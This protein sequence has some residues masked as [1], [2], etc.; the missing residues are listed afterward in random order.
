MASEATG[1]A[2]LDQF[3]ADLRK[4][5]EQAGQPSLRAMSRTAHYSHTALSG[6][7][8]S[9]RL[10]SL[11]LTLAFVGACGGDQSQWQARWHQVSGRIGAGDGEEPAAQTAD[12]R[13]RRRWRWRWRWPMTVAAVGLAVGSITGVAV[14]MMSNAAHPAQSGSN[15]PASGRSQGSRC[16]ARPD[17]GDRPLVPCDD[18]RFVADVTIPDGTTVRAGQEF[19]KTWE[20][21]NTGLVPWQ[22]R[23]M[24]RQGVM[25]GQGLCTSASRV[26]VPATMPGQDAMI[27]VTFTAPSLPGSCRV[28]WKMTD[29]DGRLFFPYLGGLYVT[30]N[31]TG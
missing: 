15:D 4:L 28:D 30:V 6:V 7:I 26:P 23:F 24:Q 11:D 14:S 18:S 3:I 27:T 9:G 8:S 10:P 12:G 31:I 19:V 1:N 29:R 13:R 22:G 16:P 5:R 25:S 20:I 2:E 21:Q 17:P